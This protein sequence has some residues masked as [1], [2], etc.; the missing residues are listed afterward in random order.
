MLW[1]PKRFGFAGAW[2]VVEQNRMLGCEKCR[3]VTSG[4]IKSI[5]PEKLNNLRPRWK[6][7]FVISP[8]TLTDDWTGVSLRG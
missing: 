2:T 1:L 5:L 7:K 8:K 4:L 3:N 6:A